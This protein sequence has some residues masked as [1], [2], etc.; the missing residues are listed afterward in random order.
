MRTKKSVSEIAIETILRD[1]EEHQLMPWQRTYKIYFSFNYTTFNEYHGINRLLLPPGEYLTIKQ[2]KEYNEKNGTDYRI[3]AGRGLYPV[4]YFGRESQNVSE[5]EVMKLFPVEMDESKTVIGTD[6]RGWLYVRKKVDGMWEY[7]KYRSH[8]RYYG[9][10]ERQYCKNPEGKALPSRVE[11][12]EVVLENANAEEVVQDY[13]RRSGVKMVETIWY[14]CYKPGTNTVYN[15]ITNRNAPDYYCNLFH[16]IAHSA[17]HSL[18]IK[19]DY[20]TGE[21]IAEICAGLCCAECG[22]TE[23]STAC[24]REYENTLA[25]VEAWKKK[26]EDW[27]AKFLTVVGTADRCFRYIMGYGDLES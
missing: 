10:I 22:I 12:G 23:Y 26:I 27:G 14:P 20:A 2:L 1:V 21:C 7:S 11:S 25:Y 3:E 16:E 15:N 4:F 5:A 19:T 24:S 6:S 18:G 17:Q 13:L 8:S 9:V